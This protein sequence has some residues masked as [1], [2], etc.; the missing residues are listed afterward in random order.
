[1][2]EKAELSRKN[3]AEVF[4]TFMRN[5]PFSSEV[6]AKEAWAFLNEMRNKLNVMREQ[7]E[8]LRDDLAIFG[9]SFGDNMDLSRL[10][11]VSS[12]ST[13]LICNKMLLKKKHKK[14]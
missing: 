14:C 12:N 5:G 10:D 1:M 3:A 6:T 9:L 13:A 8:D 7:D 4:D 2:L 11:A